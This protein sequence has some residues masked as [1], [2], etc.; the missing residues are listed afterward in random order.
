MT[1]DQQRTGHDRGTPDSEG[2]DF[3]TK[4][5]ELQLGRRA[6]EVAD[7]AAKVVGDTVAAAGT[8]AHANRDTLAGFLAKAEA[9]F[10]KQTQGKYHE[11][12]EK[13]RNGLVSGIDVIAA[14]RPGGADAA[15]EAPDEHPADP[16]TSRPGPSD[17]YS[18]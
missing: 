8:A 12:A 9:A 15:G 18:I 2:T 1:T 13:V 14:Q 7:L 17:S 11:H 3:R 4:L 16:F 10:D 5:D 6:Q